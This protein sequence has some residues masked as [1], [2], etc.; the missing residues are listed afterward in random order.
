MSLIKDYEDKK[1]NRAELSEIYGLSPGDINELFVKFKVK[2]WDGFI[3]QKDKKN[4]IIKLYQGGK[5]RRQ[6]S[7]II[8]LPMYKVSRIIR[9]AG[10]KFWDKRSTSYTEEEIEKLKEFLKNKKLVNFPQLA[11]EYGMPLNRFRNIFYKHIAKKEKKGSE[12][13]NPKEDKSSYAKFFYEY[14]K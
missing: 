10:I 6:I 14:N 1:Y 9:G 11:K 4:K 3:F 7:E 12:F 8:D 2:I 5:T 13:Y